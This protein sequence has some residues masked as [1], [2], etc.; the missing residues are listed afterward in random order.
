[1][2]ADPA[3]HGP[4]G[5]S[6]AEFEQLFREM[7][8]R[9]TAAALSL[10]LTLEESKDA[11]ETALAEVSQKWSTLD[12][13]RAW[14]YR[15]TVSAVLKIRRKEAAD[16]AALVRKIR[17]G[18]YR[19]EDHQDPGLAA[20]E[21]RLWVGSLLDS[22][23]AAQRDAVAVCFIDGFTS[24]EAAELLGTTATAI[25]ARLHAARQNL[26]RYL[27][28]DA[29]AEAAADHPWDPG[30]HQHYPRHAGGRKEA[31]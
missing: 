10:G 9:L 11:A 24:A 5:E 27:A 22:L 1:M 29:A 23:P 6:G 16:A 28:A 18:D 19:P 3:G 14:A 26:K 20:V 7:F 8:R 2:S 13:P 21:F 30:R 12:N 4:A 17:R 25:R 31:R 15:A